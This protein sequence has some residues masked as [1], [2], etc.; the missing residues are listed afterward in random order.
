[1]TDQARMFDAIRYAQQHLRKYD[2]KSVLGHAYAVEWTEDEKRRIQSVTFTLCEGCAPPPTVVIDR[3]GAVRWMQNGELHRSGNLPASY[4]KH[5]TQYFE[6]GK[7]RL[8]LDEKGMIRSLGAEQWDSFGRPME[9]T[10]E[11]AA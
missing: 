2:F 10:S 1:M 8:C 6:H 4:G 3:N 9:P 7:E 5:Y 11:P